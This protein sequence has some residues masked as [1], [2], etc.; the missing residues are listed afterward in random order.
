ML[1]RRKLLTTLSAASA[2]VAQTPKRPNTLFILIDD[3]RFNALACL[4]H[5]WLV[6][7]NIDRLAKE[8]MTF[9]NAFVTTPLCSPSR[10]SYLTGRWAHSHGVLD[11][12]GHNELSHKLVTFPALQQKAGYETAYVGKWHMGNDDSA[13]PGFDHWVSF[14]GQGQYFDPVINVNGTAAKQEGLMTD[15]LTNHAV[16]VLKRPRQKPFSL[17]LAHKAVHAPFTPPDRH[18]GLYANA[19]I[20]RHPNKDDRGSVA[21]HRDPKAAGAGPADEVVR[22][23]MR[24]L[25]AVDEGLGEILKTLES[26]GQ[27]DNTLI[28]FTSDNGY[29]HGD[30]GLGDKRAAYDEALRIPMLARY[31]AWIKAGSKSD[32]MVLN[33][34]IAPTLLEASGAGPGPQMKG[35]SFA[36]IL[37]GKTP[38]NWRKDFYSEYF[39]EKQFS[40]V[41]SWHAVRAERWK[42]V[43]YK[44]HPEWNELYDLK[45]DPYEM[46]NVIKENARVKARMEGRLAA[47]E[48]ET[49]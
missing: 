12:T 20:P 30:H 25:A 46:K 41:P 27:L 19:E 21:V 28:L 14:K 45:V 1:T 17:Y 10:A 36:A 15:I 43:A 2:A 23:Q 34:D 24:L 40:R 32:A 3:L 5:P 9:T 4:G 31:P 35:K 38:K 8:G 18:K 39:E 47:L 37:K 29:F 22:N 33:A 16:E 13:R 7:P 48:K 49:A 6:T 11:N 26:T 42:Y 44:E